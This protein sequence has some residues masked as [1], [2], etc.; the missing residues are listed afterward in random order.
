VTDD[1]ATTNSL[2]FKSTFA[3]VPAKVSTGHSRLAEV[4]GV[5]FC[6]AAALC[7]C[8][9]VSG[10]PAINTIGAKHANKIAVFLHINSPRSGLSHCRFYFTAI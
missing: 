5:I 10:L 9:R 8:G 6:A 1:D 4:A 3:I 7:P 2:C